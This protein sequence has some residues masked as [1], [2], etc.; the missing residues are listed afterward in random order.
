MD[1]AEREQANQE[2]EGELALA[3]IALAEDDLRHA[4]NHISG[5][6]GAAPWLP[7]AHE[8]LAAVAARSTDGGLDLFPLEPGYIGTV[9]AHAHLLAGRDPNRALGMLCQA[10]AHDPERPWADV[11]WVR[12]IDPSRLDPN[13]LTRALISVVQ[14]VGEPIAESRRPANQVYLDLVAR[15]IA[16]HPNEANLHGV[17]SALARRFGQTGRAVEWGDRGFRL[18]ETKLTTTWYAYALRAH[19]RLDDAVAIMHRGFERNPL[20]LDLRADVSSWLAAEGRLD[21]AIFNIEEAMRIDPTYDCAVHTAHRLRFQRDRDPKHLIALN[22]FIRDNP[23]T[24]HTHTDLAQ[25]CDRQWWLD[26]PALPT[27]AVVNVMA[28]LVDEA[29]SLAT[30]ALSALE[31]PSAI[32]LLRRTY[33]RIAIEIA[34][35][36]PA[37]MTRPLR[38]GPELWRYEGLTASPAIGVPA[39]AIADLLARVT[40]IWWPDPV[41]AY[42]AALPLGEIPPAELLALLV[43]PPARPTN[44]PS[45]PVGWW[46]RCTQV[47]ACLGLL[48]C[49]SVGSTVDRRAL[50]TQIAYG[51]EDW[52]TEAALFA[53]IVAAWTDPSCREEVAVAVSGRFLDAVEASRKRTVTILESLAELVRITPDMP[54][55]VIDL[56]KDVIA[57]K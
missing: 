18:E 5:A 37:D 16:T 43:Y 28:Q 56:A 44:D 1:D 30:M 2:A 21:E 25:A 11:P 32:A 53:L 22:D 52:T 12:A 14:A 49:A 50:L 55:E 3:R 40:Q 51:I 48:H 57:G 42:D 46:E 47:F 31:V 8:L 41:S 10:S 20:D 34:G 17:G 45:L 6:I 36:V 24:S 7:E 54:D 13:T 15:A 29:T 38:P 35:D 33:P 39:P 23:V 27:E 19:G 4:A 26:R 9:V